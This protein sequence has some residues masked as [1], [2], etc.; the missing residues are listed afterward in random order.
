MGSFTNAW[1]N[2]VLDHVL[3]TAAL[4]QD[5][6]LYLALLTGD[7]TDAGTM[8]N[9][10][11]DPASNAVNY[12]RVALT[13]ADATWRLQSAPSRTIDNASEILFNAASGGNWGT[14]THF[15]VLNHATSQVGATYCVAHGQFTASKVINDGDQAR[16]AAYELDISFNTGGLSNYLARAMLSHIFRTTSYTQPTIHVG[17]S[18]TNP[19]DVAAGT[20][21]GTTLSEPSGNNYSR[22]THTSWNAS[23]SGVATNN[24]AI[25][26]PEASGAWGKMTYI[27]LFDAHAVG[28]GNL[29]MYDTVSQSRTVSS[30]DTPRFSDE[31]L[32]ISLD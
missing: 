1:E 9:E 21:L 6:T 18:T 4:S 32:S 15:A 31:E 28:A 29:L 23:S 7:P 8:T 27:C 20:G 3:G 16:I 17:F 25:T 11:A 5:A 24:G 10:V 14:I 22:E 26:F 19:G 2:K 12:A 13:R 30:Q